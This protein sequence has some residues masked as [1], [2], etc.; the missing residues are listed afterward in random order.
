MGSLCGWKGG[1]G[2]MGKGFEKGDIVKKEVELGK[3]AWE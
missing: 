3:D 1:R 2:K